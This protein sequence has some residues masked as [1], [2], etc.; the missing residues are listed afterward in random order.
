MVETSA[1]IDA[2]TAKKIAELLNMDESA[3]TIPPVGQI[4]AVPPILFNVSR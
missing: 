4:D 2:M 1:D 3:F